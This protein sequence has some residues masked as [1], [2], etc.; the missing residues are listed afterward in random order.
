MGSIPIGVARKLVFFV[1]TGAIPP[2]AVLTYQ[3]TFR[4]AAGG[5]APVSAKTIQLPLS[6]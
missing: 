1:D 4:A 6:G 3:S 2:A 5:L